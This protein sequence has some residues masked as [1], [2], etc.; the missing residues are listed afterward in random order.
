MLSLE[1]LIG[2]DATHLVSLPN[3][4]STKK[5][6]LA[7]PEAISALVKLQQL[8]EK[9]N[10]SFKVISSY[11]SFD[12]QKILWNKKFS[13]QRPVLD[14]NET[15]I[16]ISALPTIDRIHSIMLFSAL[17]GASRHHWGS[18]FDIF[19]AAALESGY[20][21]QLLASEFSVAGVAAELNQWLSDKL[22]SSAFSR[23][24]E[25]YQHGIAAEPWH[26]SYLPIA[27]PALSALSSHHLLAALDN[28]KDIAGQ[29]I[30]CANMAR[31]YEQ[32][33]KN[34]CSEIKLS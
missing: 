1:Q 25:T 33:I 15:P 17:P 5:G 7:H 31:L 2:K 27:K 9:D 3:A 10:L 22:P 34:I 16:D 18:D 23:P 19:P 14:L 6:Q 26:I 20:Q 8:A 29:A 32:Y 11:R 21:A 28:E 30:I 24:Y 13:G 4:L 12:E